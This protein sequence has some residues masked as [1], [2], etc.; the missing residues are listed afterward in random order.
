MDLY[1]RL[2]KHLDF[3]QQSISGWMTEFQRAMGL[4]GEMI[5]SILTENWENKKPIWVMGMLSNFNPE[6][7]SIVQ[8]DVLDDYLSKEAQKQGKEVHAMETPGV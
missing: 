3:V 7:I 8:E 1:V 5:F 6:T 2:K 4:N